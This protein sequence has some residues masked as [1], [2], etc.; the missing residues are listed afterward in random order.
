M[1]MS[2]LR[3]SGETLLRG[4]GGRGN[5][6]DPVQ[7]SVHRH[8]TSCIHRTPWRLG[9][10]VFPGPEAPL[11]SR[12]SPQPRLLPP[13]RTR[14][15]AARA[16]AAL[17]VCVEMLE[18][19][20]SSDRSD[21]LGLQTRP[22]PLGRTPVCKLNTRENSRRPTGFSLHLGWCHVTERPWRHNPTTAQ[23]SQL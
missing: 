9:F 6:T 3:A 4:P 17:F 13:S 20:E 18:M 12:V 14:P 5:V 11:G 10:R 15:Y 8:R 1:C 21:N 23:S 2:S 16:R 19:A 7:A 22:D